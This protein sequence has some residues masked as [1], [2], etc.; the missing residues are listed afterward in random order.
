MH[1][2]TVLTVLKSIWSNT[3][4]RREGYRRTEDW[5]IR[6]FTSP[7]RPQSSRRSKVLL[8]IDFKTVNTVLSQTFNHKICSEYAIRKSV[9]RGLFLTLK[10]SCLLFLSNVH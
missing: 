1:E 7:C 9:V 2:R 6:I 4:N 8:K 5:E 10:F 3:Y